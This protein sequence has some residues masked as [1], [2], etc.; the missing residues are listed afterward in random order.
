VFVRERER[1]RERERDKDRRKDNRNKDRLA[2]L[3]VPGDS[4]GIDIGK[5]MGCPYSLELTSYHMYPGSW[6]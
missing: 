2:L 3:C 6:P 4:F 5:N 1:E